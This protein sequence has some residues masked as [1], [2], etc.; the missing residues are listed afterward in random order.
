MM[1]R[2]TDSTNDDPMEEE[3][4]EDE[5]EDGNEDWDEQ[6]EEGTYCTYYTL[7][8]KWNFYLHCIALHTIS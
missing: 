1:M 5:D 6:E 3:D 7:V 2:I 8:S 4:L